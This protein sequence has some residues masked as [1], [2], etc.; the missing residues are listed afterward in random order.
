[1]PSF[2][3]PPSL[4]VL[5]VVAG[6]YGAYIRVGVVQ[7]Q[8]NE[9]RYV[10]KLNAT[11]VAALEENSTVSYDFPTGAATKGAIDGLYKAVSE[12]WAY[13]SFLMLV[14]SI[15]SF[16]VSMA[17]QF[18]AVEFDF[19]KVFQ[20]LYQAPKK[21]RHAKQADL[22]SPKFNY[23]LMLDFQMVAFTYIG[24]MWT[25]NYA[26]QYTSIATQTL[27][28]SAKMVPIVVG[29]LI[30]YRKTYPW[31]DYFTV[32]FVTGGL[33]LYNL[34]EKSKKGHGGAQPVETSQIG[35]L[36]CILS[37]LCD[38]ITGPRQDKVNSKYVITGLEH[39]MYTN[40]FAILPSAI[41]TVLFDFVY[42]SLDGPIA[43]CLRHP[44]VLSLCLQFCLLST[45]GQL[46]IFQGLNLLGALYLSVVTTTRKC[47][48]VMI[49]IFTKPNVQVQ[50]IQWLGIALVYVS[51]LIQGYFSQ[52][53]KAR[54]KKAAVAN[55]DLAR[56]LHPASEMQSNPNHTI[57]PIEKDAGRV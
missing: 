35:I 8:I 37:L 30:V 22:S 34:F 32:A 43:F 19:R 36:F 11:A 33:I 46:F 49:D 53:D 38:G 26:L 21:D 25:T 6:I 13:P 45:V 14:M 3:I 42:T 47:F 27:I 4:M 44:A 16:V 7:G 18:A 54:K 15:G 23:E 51:L 50:P 1:M 41:L 57:L 10:W 31:Y 20:A 2:T 17:F 9:P 28:K 39:M 12:S 29:G 5:I 55:A 52:M 24:A 48:T 40:L 56:T